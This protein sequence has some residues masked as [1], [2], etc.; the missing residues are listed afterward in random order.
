MTLS[1][2]AP[3]ATFTSTLLNAPSSLKVLARSRSFI[4]KTPKRLLSGSVSPGRASKTYSGE[5][6]MPTIFNR[7]RAP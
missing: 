5:R 6:A 7:C 1:G 2:L 4:Q 3:G